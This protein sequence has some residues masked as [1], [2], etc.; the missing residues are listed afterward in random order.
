MRED[1]DAPAPNQ[2]P[3]FLENTEKL[4]AVLS[5]LDYGALKKLWQCSDKIALQNQSRLETM[6][7]RK[8]FTPALFAYDGIQYQYLN[9]NAFTDAELAYIEAHLCILS[10]FYGLLHPFDGVTPYRLEMQ[11]KLAV[12]EKKNLYEFWGDKIAQALF[13][14]TSC[15]VNLCSKEY[16]RCV[17]DYLPPEAEVI[18]CRFGE[19]K[20]G[21]IIEKGTMC[22]MARGAMVRYAAEHRCE[23][24]GELKGFGD[25]G[26]VYMESLSTESEYI[27]IKER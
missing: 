12:G 24:P 15:A 18:T 1:D 9:P 25:L 8:A 5:A 19:I 20:D 16:S 21:K 2:L 3:Q 10:G 13:K 17:L 27:F 26:Y 7:L 14:E 6:E 4:L 23:T 11:A 22:K